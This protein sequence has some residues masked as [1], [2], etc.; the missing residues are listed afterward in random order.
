[1][2]VIDLYVD[3]V[4][5]FAFVSARWLLDSAD[6]EHTVTLKQMSLATLHDEDTGADSQ[7]PMLIRSRRIG[8]VFAAVDRHHGHEVFTPLFLALGTRL[9]P[10]G[11]DTDDTAAA[12]AALAEAGL[13]LTLLAALDDTALDPEVAAAHQLS[14]TALGG[15]G[16]SPIVAIDGHGFSGPVLTAPPPRHRA[17]DLLAALVT[18]ATTPGFAALNRPYQ[19]PPAFTATE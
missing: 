3:P 5:P 7:D 6:D 15:R 19:G 17:A 2:A 14:Q 16:G 10:R 13:D 8:R 1:M 11:P 18:A 12:A 4:C 9:H